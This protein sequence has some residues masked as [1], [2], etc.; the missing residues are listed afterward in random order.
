MKKDNFKE[1][2]INEIY[3]KDNSW[4][5][6]IYERNINNLDDYALFYRGKSITY[7]TFFDNVCK[8]AEFLKEKNINKNDTVPV[9][10]TL[11]PE[12]IYILGA[13]NL[14]GAKINIF[15]YSFDK[16]YI[17]E[18]LD[19]C[20]KELIFISDDFLDEKMNLINNE[21]NKNKILISLTNSLPLH[22]N[23]YK[24]ID[25]EFITFEN[26]A[27]KF[28]D[29]KNNIFDIGDL[30]SN[31][32]KFNDVEIS[33]II[34]DEIYGHVS[35]K[36][37]FT[38]TYSSGSTN[39]TRPKGIVHDNLSYLTSFRF[40]DADLSG[41]P[42]TSKICSLMNIPAHSNTSLSS[43]LSDTLS[44]CGTVAIEPVYHKDFFIRSLLINK[45]NFAAA[46]RS[47]WIETAKKIMYDPDFYKVKM[48]YLYIP[49]S[50][51]EPIAANEEKFINK[52]FRKAK[53][54]KD[55]LPVSAV[56]SVG[57][58]DCEHGGLFFT[59]YKSF[60]EKLPKYSL[61]KKTCG[62]K[63]FGMAET[64]ILD[65]YGKECNPNQLGILAANSPCTM[66]KYDNNV[67]ATNKFFVKDAKNKKW[68][69]CNAYA[70]KDEYGNIHMKGRVGNEI[71]LS[72]Q[73]KVPLFL[74]ADEIL[75]DTKNIL[76]CEV[77]LIDDKIVAHIEFQP[78]CKKNQENINKVLYG[79]YCR[80][81]NNFDG[82][83]IN[84]IYFKIRDNQESFPLTGC[85]KRNN[86]QLISEGFND[87]FKFGNIPSSKEDE[88]KKSYCKKKF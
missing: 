3:K 2:A 51:G 47:F 81:M 43:C 55:K 46:T 22:R 61:T 80:C 15:H 69:N 68:A 19:R 42:S 26:N 18:I 20:S 48:P 75:K 25:K 62:M 4:I 82:E 77:V 29:S 30:I 64:I 17:N 44:Q 52:A 7:R 28:R 23:F 87:T 86:L 35:A 14:I 66:T 1:I 73:K 16:N 27:K 32:E 79:I 38:I 72:N 40:H 85:G 71:I 34:G 6:E 31:K 24:D 67:D 78:N 63:P 12:L 65:K 11:C 88:I 74:I 36:D 45:P 5:K 58:G 84:K 10:M 54:G 37:D 76:S 60:Q 39:T 53:F 21:N 70:T 13:V 83:V 57:G 9:C 41:L 49:T 56:I 50:V 8:Y 33:K 59:L